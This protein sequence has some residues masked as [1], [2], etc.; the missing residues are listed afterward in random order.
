MRLADTK[1]PEAARVL[2]ILALQ[3][4]RYRDEPSFREAVDDVLH[5]TRYIAE[6]ACDD[7]VGQL[8]KLHAKR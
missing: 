4:N 7:I 2:A 6:R 8:E 3:S 5:M 1:L